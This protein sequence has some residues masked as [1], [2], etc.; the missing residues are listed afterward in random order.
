MDVKFAIDQYNTSFKEADSKFNNV[1]TEFQSEIEQLKYI[2]K[3]KVGITDMHANF[4]ELGDLLIVKFK[5]IEDC[6]D[7]LRDMLV[8]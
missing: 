3:G 2:Q 1:R 5:Q 8:Y 6:K 7:G 4:K